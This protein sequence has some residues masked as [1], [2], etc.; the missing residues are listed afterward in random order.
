[1]RRHRRPIPG[2][3][4]DDHHE[5]DRPL[6]SCRQRQSFLVRA[7]QLRLEVGGHSL[8][9]VGLNLGGAEEGE[10]DGESVL[11]HGQ[12]DLGLPLVARFAQE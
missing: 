11:A 12:L 6:M 7:A 3:V 2:G 10:I 8:D 1:M 9:L 4:L 5:P